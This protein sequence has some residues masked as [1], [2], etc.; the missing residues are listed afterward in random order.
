ME[1]STKSASMTS[2]AAAMATRRERR[3]G[4]ADQDN[5]CHQYTKNS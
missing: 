1:S 3:I 4:H 2:T 5:R